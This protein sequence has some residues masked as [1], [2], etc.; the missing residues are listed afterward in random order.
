MDGFHYIDTFSGLYTLEAL[1]RSKVNCDFT[2][3]LIVFENLKN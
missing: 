3:L 2:V 1:W